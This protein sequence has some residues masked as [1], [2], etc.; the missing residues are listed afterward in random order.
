MAWHGE[1]KMGKKRHSEILVILS[2]MVAQIN[3]GMITGR[4]LKCSLQASKIWQ[5]FDSNVKKYIY[6][7]HSVSSGDCLV[8]N[9]VKGTSVD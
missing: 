3:N 9:N 8:P 1:K 4:N 7:F 5:R 2:Q 6:L